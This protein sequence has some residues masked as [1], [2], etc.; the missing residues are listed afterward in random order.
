M[1]LR[2]GTSLHRLGAA[3][4]AAPFLEIAATSYPPGKTE[5]SLMLAETYLFKQSHEDLEAALQHNSAGLS[6]AAL[7]NS[8]RDRALLPACADSARARSPR[9]I[10]RSS[11][12]GFQRRGRQSGHIVL[13]AQAC[14]HDKRYSEAIQ[15]LEPVALDRGLERIYPAQAAYLARPVC[16][17][18]G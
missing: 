15:I 11:D 12:K 3:D 16:R 13:R 4:E 18:T 1:G 8:D 6:N 14:M 2:A 9:R 10:R 7:S 17:A 5:A